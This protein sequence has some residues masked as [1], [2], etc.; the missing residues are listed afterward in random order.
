MSSAL[1][2]NL[3]TLTQQHSRVTLRMHHAL[4]RRCARLG[5]FV[6]RRCSAPENALENAAASR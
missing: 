4:S 3:E 1:S 6:V 5:A 2:P